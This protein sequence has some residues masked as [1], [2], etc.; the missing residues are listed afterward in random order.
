MGKLKDFGLEI[1]A[2]MIV[3]VG[4][5]LM[6]FY[7]TEIVSFLSVFL[8]MIGYLI[9]RPLISHYKQEIV[10]FFTNKDEN[11]ESN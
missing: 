11:D 9:L 2:S 6:I 10:L 7:L 4:V 5:G 8:G 3:T 1:I